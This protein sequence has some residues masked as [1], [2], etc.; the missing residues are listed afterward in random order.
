MAKASQDEPALRQLSIFLLKEAV[1]SAEDALRTDATVGECSPLDGGKQVGR[2]FIDRRPSKPPGWARF[3]DGYF[4]T[5]DRGRVKSTAGALFIEVRDRLFA[6][7]FGHGRYLLKPECYEERFG[8]LVALN[9]VEPDSLRSIDKRSFNA[10]L[11]HSRVESSKMATALEFGVDIDQDLLRALTGIPSDIAIGQ[12][13][14][15]I[16]ALSVQARI[17]LARL[18]ALLEQY[19]QKFS[20]IAYKT[21][22]AWV[23]RI[24]E[25][26]RPSKVDQL[27]DTLVQKIT[28]REFDRCWLSVPVP[29]SWD[30]VSGFKYSRGHKAPEHTDIHF[31]TFL[32]SI[33]NPDNVT[34]D[35]LKTHSVFCVDDQ[36]MIIEQ[37]PVYRCTYCEI[38]ADVDVYLLNGGKWYR[39]T[40][41][42]VQEV[43]RFFDDVPRYEIALPEYC[44]GS[45]GDYNSRVAAADA[46]TYALMDAK[47]IIIGGGRSSV[48]FCDLYTRTRD[49]LHIKRYGGSG[50]L[51]H[52]FAQ[53]L[54]SAELFKTEPKF[55]ALV[56]EKL[57]ISHRTGDGEVDAS[58]FRVVFAVVSDVPGEL[59]LPFFSRLNLRHTAKRLMTIG[60][61]IALAKI[62]VDQKYKVRKKYAPTRPSARDRKKP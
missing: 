57:P 24:S 37:W 13:M 49:L 19:L 36:G 27:N 38:E 56:D 3:F 5:R 62:E 34:L 32:G 33:R 21:H 54:I 16:D 28:S 7:T 41:D 43:N 2:L 45:E 26:K 39:V 47:Q 44:D 55:R 58:Q 46:D 4:D 42:F 59:K 48:E 51:S 29:L 1:Q 15:G 25:V 52:L 12:R 60:Y 14:S 23:D 6:V 35:T 30:R 20:S 9:S 10:L 18:P 53:G 17:D 31:E 40:R 8:L 22:F 61:R 11:T 50:V